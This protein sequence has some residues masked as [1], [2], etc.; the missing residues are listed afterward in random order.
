VSPAA[1]VRSVVAAVAILGAGAVA[2]TVA[3]A[4]EDGVGP[5]LTFAAFS[6]LQ[7][8]N[9]GSSLRLQARDESETWQMDE[10]I[11]VAAVMILPPLGVVLA[12][13]PAAAIA[14]LIY[15]RRDTFAKTL[16]NVGQ[17]LVA[18]AA[19]AAVYELV[20]ETARGIGWQTTSAAILAAVVFAVVNAFVVGLM[21]RVAYGTGICES[22]TDGFRLRVLQWGCSVS[23]GLLAGLAAAA[24]TWAAVFAI[25]P[26]GIVQVVVAEHLRARRDRERIDGLF[27]AAVQAHA[28]VRPEEV[29]E[30]LSRSA[31]QLLRAEVSAVLPRQPEDHEW[32]VQLAVDG[33]TEWYLVVSDR[34]GDEPMKPEDWKL[35]DAL[36]AVGS[37]AME[38]ARLVEEIRRQALHDPLTGLANQLL[39]DD[40]VAQAI[41]RAHRARERFAVYVVDL[42]AFKKVNDSLGHTIGNELLEQVAERLLGAVREVDTV[43]RLGGDHFTLLM[44]GV[45]TPETAGVMAEKIL[46]V[47]RRPFH[48]GEHELFMT[49]SAGIAFYPEDGTHPD[50]LL[51]NA[52]SAMHRAKEVGRD[53]YQIY[54]TGMNELA[55][56]RLAR[57]TELHNALK[58]RELRVRY[59]PQIDLRTGQIVGAEALVRWE[60]PILGLVGPQEFVPLAEESGLI[61]DVDAFVMRE[62]CRQTQA[63]VDEGLKPIRIAVNLSGR[64][65]QSDRVLDLIRS[66]LVETALD[67]AQL[68]LEVTESVAVREADDTR[69][70]LDRVRDLGCQ[71][72]IDDF[73]TGYSVLGRLQHF[74]IDRLKIDRSFIS[75]IKSSHGE[76]PIV[77]AM[78]AMARSLR[79][80]VVAEGVETLEQQTYLRNHGCDTAQGFLFSHPV[81]ADELSRLLRTPSIGFSVTG[82]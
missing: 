4:S 12:V 7:F 78:I 47:L 81:E 37:S 35:L 56:L 73:G 24:H 33:E 22:I 29:Q 82:V 74:P 23:V 21:V 67:P 68:E 69:S 20:N 46:G 62:A 72:A 52:D 43:A 50:H 58:R 40:R 31:A 6:A 77:A 41:T 51:R 14:V 76:A 65:F 48:L 36:S 55:H 19:G 32:G 9:W 13:G 71:L 64:H 8:A 42:D 54:A 70:L 2:A 49:A 66:V 18:S 75:E 57:E 61:V 63:W 53:S 5:L 25:P 38:N 34:H 45:G 79:L 30:A 26:L 3:F 39:F 28:S 80:E 27:Q 60:H 10:A 59:Q 17:L 44:P 11:L 15:Q 16:F 1:R